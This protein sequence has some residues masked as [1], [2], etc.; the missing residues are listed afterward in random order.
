[1]LQKYHFISFF[2]KFKYNFLVKRVF[3]LLNA[4]FAMAILSVISHV[5]LAAPVIVLP[6]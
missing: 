2:H 4:A 6:K 5:H 3:F 1:M